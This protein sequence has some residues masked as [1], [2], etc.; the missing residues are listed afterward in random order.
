MPGPYP[1]RFTDELKW[2]N[3]K[4]VVAVDDE[5]RVT[6]YFDNS[7]N[8]AQTCAYLGAELNY[9]EKRVLLIL[10]TYAQMPIDEIEITGGELL[11]ELRYGDNG[12]YEF[13]QRAGTFEDMEERV[14][15]NGGKRRAR[16]ARRATRKVKRSKRRGTRKHH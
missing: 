12:W 15:Q 13:I 14:L 10:F 1:G 4:P 9:E 2:E 7:E 11:L 5:R 16:R 8:Y 6:G 3:F